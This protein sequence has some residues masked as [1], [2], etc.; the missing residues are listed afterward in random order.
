MKT[1]ITAIVACCAALLPVTQAQ[2][3]EP[4]AKKYG[5]FKPGDTFTMKV[6]TV[7]PIGTRPKGFP[8]FTKGQNVKFTIGTKG[9]LKGPGFS[10]NF[11]P[12]GSSGGENYYDNAPPHPTTLVHQAVVETKGSPPKPYYIN[13]ALRNS[14]S[15]GFY[16][17]V[18]LFGKK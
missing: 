9:E 7:A 17:V 8:V 16:Q 14:S 1:L 11:K 18:Y 5:D 12:E 15:A 4:A 2:A 3:A 6:A 13:L 10:I